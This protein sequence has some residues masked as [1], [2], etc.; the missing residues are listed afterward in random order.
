MHDIV[1]EPR[2]TLILEFALTVHCVAEPADLD[3]DATDE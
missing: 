2:R 3:E 1:L